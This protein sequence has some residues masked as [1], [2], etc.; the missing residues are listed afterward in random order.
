MKYYVALL[1][2]DRSVKHLL[3][4]WWHFETGYM[5]NVIEAF[6]NHEYPDAKYTRDNAG[7][8]QYADGIEVVWIKGF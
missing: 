2:A 6:V 7:V 3:F 1:C 8:I 5:D 4:T